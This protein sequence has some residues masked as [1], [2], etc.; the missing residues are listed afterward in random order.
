VSCS[1]RYQDPRKPPRDCVDHAKL[2]RHETKSLILPDSFTKLDKN[3]IPCTNIPVMQYA[4]LNGASVN[5]AGES[6]R[7]HQTNL[8]DAVA[9][10]TVQ[11][12]VLEPD[13]GR[14]FSHGQI[15]IES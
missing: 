13:G 3:K 14:G 2:E 7:F 6:V 1:Y 4:F 15:F 11:G 5:L 9:A 12:F 10:S 8:K